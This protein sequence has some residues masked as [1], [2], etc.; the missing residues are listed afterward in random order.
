V[1][2]MIA[3]SYLESKPALV[4]RPVAV[5]QQVSATGYHARAYSTVY[6]AAKRE[7]RIALNDFVWV[8]ATVQ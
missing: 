4:V 7:Y 3:K 6:D 8:V 5:P 2:A 1:E